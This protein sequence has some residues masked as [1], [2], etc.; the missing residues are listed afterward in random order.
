MIKTI[1]GGGTGEDGR[2]K[3]GVFQRI[4]EPMSDI[5]R[6][7]RQGWLADL[8][9]TLWMFVIILIGL[10]PIAIAAFYFLFWR[11]G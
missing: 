4:E 8:R 10:S 3:K 1:K 9:D 5:E 11:K 7:M 2:Y 6:Q